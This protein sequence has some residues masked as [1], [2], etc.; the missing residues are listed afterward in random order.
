MSI[1]TEMNAPIFRADK[2]KEVMEH[3]SFTGELVGT[4]TDLLYHHI[5]VRLI[6]LS[7]VLYTTLTRLRRIRPS[8]VYE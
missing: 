2:L 5:L 8:L 7:V 1:A 6:L 4:G 3:P